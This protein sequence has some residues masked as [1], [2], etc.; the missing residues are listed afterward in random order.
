VSDL[1]K[2]RPY[3]IP[4]VRPLTNLHLYE[5]RKMEVCSISIKAKMMRGVSNSAIF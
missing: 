2:E 5:W 3:A 4:L 1:D